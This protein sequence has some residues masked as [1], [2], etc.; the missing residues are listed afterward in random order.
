MRI[1]GE[2]WLYRCCTKR[3]IASR[4]S[5]NTVLAVDTNELIRAFL[6]AA[7]A[8]ISL[9]LDEYR[10][11]KRKRVNGFN[12]WSISRVKCVID[13]VLGSK[14]IDFYHGFLNSS[15]SLYNG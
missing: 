10:G 2:K 13:L 7:L 11:I 5:Q 14:L 8:C 3:R 12:T 9:S 15:S 6:A 4:Q 1:V